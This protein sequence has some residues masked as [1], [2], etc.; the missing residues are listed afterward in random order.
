VGGAARARARHDAIEPV[1]VM[2][3]ECMRLSPRWAAE[4]RGFWDLPDDFEWAAPTP[5][6]KA[7]KAARGMV[8]P[9]QANAKF[10]AGSEVH[11]GPATGGRPPGA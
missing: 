3:A 4:Y 2:Y 8:T 7:T 1:R 9:E 10:L 5:T 11:G 6:V